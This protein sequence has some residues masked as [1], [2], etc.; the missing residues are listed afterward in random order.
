LLTVIEIAT[1]NGCEHAEYKT[2]AIGVHEF[3]GPEVLELEDAAT[4]KPS[5]GQV[6][7][8]I[9]AAEVNPYDT[10]MRAGGRYYPA[11]RR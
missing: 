9:H 3:R 6:L 5:A 2:K 7:V 4:P 10:N 11:S 8:R 1:F